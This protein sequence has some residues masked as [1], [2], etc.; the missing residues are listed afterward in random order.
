MRTN[1]PDQP[2]QIM[3]HTGCPPGPISGEPIRSGEGAVMPDLN[4]AL[5]DDRKRLMDSVDTT[6]APEVL[7]LSIDRTQAAYVQDRRSMVVSRYADESGTRRLASERQRK[8]GL[9]RR[10]SFSVSNSS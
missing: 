6:A 5:I 7:S 9:A 4:F 1:S 3:R 2:S 8:N 10:Y